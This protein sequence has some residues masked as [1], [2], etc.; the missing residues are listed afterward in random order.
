LPVRAFN[1]LQ[2][3]E[4]VNIMTDESMDPGEPPDGQGGG[5]TTTSDAEVSDST[6]AVDPPDNQGGGTGG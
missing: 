4:N 5:A 1:D 6:I 3:I 2:T